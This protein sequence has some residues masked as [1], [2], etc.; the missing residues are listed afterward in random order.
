MRSKARLIV[1]DGT[2]GS[3]K[4]TQAKL[5]LKYLKDKGYKTKYIDFPRYYTSFHGK[6]VARYL[7]GE[8]GGLNEVSPYLSSLAY[9]LDRLTAKPEMER[10]LR[11]GNI[12]VSNRYTSA[13]MAHQTARLPKNKR[14]DFLDWLYKMEY[15]VHKLPKEDV[16]LFLHVPV[17]IGQQ[18]VDKKRKSKR[19]YA[20][21]QK[22]DIH[23]ASLDYLRETEKMYISLSKR[24]RH[25]V[26][27]PCVDEKGKLKT[28]EEI[29]KLVVEALKKEKIV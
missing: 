27:I 1:I 4:E 20:K 9:A 26:R 11:S 6:V 7:T 10:W 12:V 16:V 2:D 14:K 29:H 13:N 8:F 17:E 25:W 5:L 21:G 24:F 3:G 28:R 22:R 23:E 15:S 19:A 18:L